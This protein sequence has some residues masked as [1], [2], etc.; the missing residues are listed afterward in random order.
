MTLRA[1]FDI[2]DPSDVRALIDTVNSKETASED[3]PAERDRLSETA[4]TS[5]DSTAESALEPHPDVNWQAGPALADA[6]LRAALPTMDDEA[7]NALGLAAIQL[8]TSGRVAS[9][10]DAAYALP[11]FDRLRSK[12]EARGTHFF[13]DLAPSASTDVFYGRFHAGISEER[14]DA[15]FPHLFT[16]PSHPPF[17][18]LV[19]MFYDATSESIWLMLRTT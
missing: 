18:A 7:R 19:H 8:D 6:E 9:L 4:A 12:E 17:V 1:E 13:F 15:R 16:A 11:V 10:N 2:D 3:L 14:L 5:G